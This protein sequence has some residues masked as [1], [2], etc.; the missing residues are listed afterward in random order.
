MMPDS[1]ASVV[2]QASTGKLLKIGNLVY[3]F[4]TIN[5]LTTFGVTV[6][7]YFAGKSHLL[8]VIELPGNSYIQAFAEYSAVLISQTNLTQI[9]Y[10]FPDYRNLAIYKTFEIIGPFGNITSL[11]FYNDTIIFADDRQIGTISLIDE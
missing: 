2:S 9:L 10:Y 3:L 5:F 11:D 1:Y 6:N 8:S 7:Q 4:S